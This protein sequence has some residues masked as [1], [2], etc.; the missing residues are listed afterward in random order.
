MH[1]VCGGHG[2]DLG[3]LRSLGELGENPSLYIQY[4]A[5][6]DVR[7]QQS[8][9]LCLVD[10]ASRNRRGL[11]HL[12]ENESMTWHHKGQTQKTAG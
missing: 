12:V 11:C 10:C 4:A 5:N 9:S 3:S 7:R 8:S 6:G 2:V 1:V